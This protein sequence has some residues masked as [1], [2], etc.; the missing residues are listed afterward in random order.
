[1]LIKGDPNTIPDVVIS[2]PFSFMNFHLIMIEVCVSET[3]PHVFKKVAKLIRQAVGPLFAFMFLFVRERHESRA[4]GQF[5]GYPSIMRQSWTK[6]RATGDEGEEALGEWTHQDKTQVSPPKAGKPPPQNIRPVF[7]AGDPDQ[8]HSIEVK[9]HWSAFACPP[10]ALHGVLLHGAMKLDAVIVL[11]DRFD[12]ILE[13]VDRGTTMEKIVDRFPTV[14]SDL[15]LQDG[16]LSGVD[17]IYLPEQEFWREMLR[18]CVL[19]RRTFNAMALNMGGLSG[20][21]PLY[22][23]HRNRSAPACQWM[24]QHLPG[25]TTR[26]FIRREDEVFEEVVVLLADQLTGEALKVFHDSMVQRL[27]RAAM[28]WADSRLMDALG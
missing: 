1:M 15:V 5:E 3:A 6:A 21:R 9:E 26:E 18:M 10:R 14:R 16:S 8:P 13:E 25:Y 20:P 7:P 23:V 17:W 24:A 19:T 27:S 2:F 28:Q 22:T 4:P 12:E 11:R